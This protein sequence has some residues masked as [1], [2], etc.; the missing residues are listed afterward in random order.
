MGN[1]NSSINPIK[2]GKVAEGQAAIVAFIKGRGDNLAE[3]TPVPKA[4]NFEDMASEL[5]DAGIG[6]V[7]CT[8]CKIHYDAQTLG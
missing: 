2:P 7:Y 6:K 1:I 8:G 4:I 3:T 5:I